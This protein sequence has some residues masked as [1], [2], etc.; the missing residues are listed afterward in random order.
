MTRGPSL[1]GILQDVSFLAG[2]RRM[3]TIHP[4]IA[5]AVQAENSCEGLRTQNSASVD[6]VN[7]VD[8][9]VVTANTYSVLP[10]GL[11]VKHLLYMN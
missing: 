1:E 7:E 5:R 11:R 4:K 6:K 8:S 3:N 9:V 10:K 2:T